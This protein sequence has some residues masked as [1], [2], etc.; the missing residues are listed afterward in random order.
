MALGNEGAHMCIDAD[1]AL[2]PTLVT[3]PAHVSDIT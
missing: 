2:T 3:N 1:S